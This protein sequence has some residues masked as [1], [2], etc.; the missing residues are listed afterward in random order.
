MQLSS[1]EGCRRHALQKLAGYQPSDLLCDQLWSTLLKAISACLLDGDPSVRRAAADELCRLFAAA[2]PGALAFDI[3]C[4]LG[5][6]CQQSLCQGISLTELAGRIHFFTR[7]LVALSD[8]WE[9]LSEEQS[10]AFVAVLCKVSKCAAPDASS[11][12]SMLAVMALV[13]SDGAWARCS[14]ARL[15]LRHAYLVA[16]VDEGLLEGLFA[17]LQAMPPHVRIWEAS[18]HDRTSEATSCFQPS[19]TDWRFLEVFTCLLS[20]L[21]FQ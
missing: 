2:M 14:L 8:C 13:D 17:L 21:V 16:C 12:P 3:A 1:S 20:S 7:A 10:C 18:Y 4:A 15:G 19:E 9:A 11:A 5:T 6:A